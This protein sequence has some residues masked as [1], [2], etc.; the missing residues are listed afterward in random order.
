MEARSVALTLPVLEFILSLPEEYQTFWL[1]NL[2]PTINGVIGWCIHDVICV[3]GD[4]KVDPLEKEVFYKRV[5]GVKKQLRYLSTCKGKLKR[6]QD[7]MAECRP[8]IAFLLKEE[9]PLTRQKLKRLFGRRKVD[10]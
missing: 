9:I 5:K 3:F 8:E 6:V 2:G 7:T 1:G 10:F 4:K